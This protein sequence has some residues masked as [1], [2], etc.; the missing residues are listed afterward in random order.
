MMQTF[1]LSYLPRDVFLVFAAFFACF[2]FGVAGS[3][4]AAALSRCFLVAIG[5]TLSA[6]AASTP[7]LACHRIP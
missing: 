1:T 3:L 5:P 4:F 2:A 7:A 6:A